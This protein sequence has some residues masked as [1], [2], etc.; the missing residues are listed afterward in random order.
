M[1]FEGPWLSKD[2]GFLKAQREAEKP[3]A[4]VN[5]PVVYRNIGLVTIAS[6]SRTPD[7]RQLV[8]NFGGFEALV[9]Y[10]EKTKSVGKIPWLLGV[11][12]HP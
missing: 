1:A 11:H 10:I 8:D 6:A 12:G 7:I 4:L 3:H 9:S 2:P 5:H